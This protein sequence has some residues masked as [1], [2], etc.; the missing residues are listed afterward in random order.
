M[1]STTS[2]EAT[3]YWT[4]GIDTVVL[5]AN[6][7]VDTHVYC[8]STFFVGSRSTMS[9]GELATFSETGLPSGTT[10][11][12]T[13]DGTPASA[14][15]P[16]EIVSDLQNSTPPYAFSVGAVPGYIASPASGS[17]S[18]SG[19]AVSQPIDFLEILP[20][21]FLVTVTESG[22]PAN[23]EWFV[24]ITGG[25]SYSSMTDTIGFLL[26]NGSYSYT[27][28]TANTTF[29]APGGAF[30]VLGGP[31]SRS[32]TFTQITYEVEFAE[33]GVP[34][35]LTWYLN[36]SNGQKF[37][38]VAGS[39]TFSE[40][41]GTYAYT[42]GAT[43]QFPK[44]YS[45]MPGTLVVHGGPQLVGA[46]FVQVRDVIVTEKNLPSG[47]TWWVNFTGGGP[48][49][50]HDREDDE[51]LRARRDVVVHGRG[52]QPRL[53]GEGAVVHGAPAAPPA[54]RGAVVRGQLPPDVLQCVVPRERTAGRVAL[55][56]RGERRW[57]V[58]RVRSDGEFP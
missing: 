16:G 51:L 47:M 57:D 42:F 30:V 3:D 58:L 24:N 26:L 44:W 23:T 25:S 48:S 15:A 13:V 28:G 7:F 5:N 22:L 29:K 11:S 31:V 50:L 27:V 6:D 18:V 54:A 36:L 32:V 35:G 34:T 40:P 4:T 21:T 41:N 17:F 8:S 39:I 46:T 12:V 37:S 56:R 52:G 10:W 53:H 43:L 1:L 55:V 49:V 9:C 45:A 14:T 20:S 2:V 33:T 19:S 38:A